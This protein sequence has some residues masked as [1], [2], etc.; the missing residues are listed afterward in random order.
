MDTVVL[1][2]RPVNTREPLLP[3]QV[4]GFVPVTPVIAGEA[5]TTIALVDAEEVQPAIVAVTL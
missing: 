5:C 3:L 4:V 1:A 2:G